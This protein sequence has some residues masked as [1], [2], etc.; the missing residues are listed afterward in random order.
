MQEL[1]STYQSLM[2]LLLRSSARRGLPLVI[3][4]AV[5]ASACWIGGLV[6]L[7]FGVAVPLVSVPLFLV[8]AAWA[9]VVEALPA[10]LLLL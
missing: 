7:A 9:V 5:A 6:T 2:M 4:L 1:L 3:A 8:F 10:E